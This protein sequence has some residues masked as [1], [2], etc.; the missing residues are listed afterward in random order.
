[1]KTLKKRRKQG[2]TNYLKRLK[3]LKG[4][5]PRIVF[6]KTNKYILAQYVQSKEAQDKVEE[7]I[8]SKILLKYGW[9][10]ESKGSLKSI[11]AAYLTGFLA[12]K[13]ILKGKKETPILDLGMIRTL[14]KSKVYGFA[15]GLVD[16]GV[17]LKIKEEIFPEENRI[18]GKHMKKDFSDAFKKIKSRIQENE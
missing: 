17:K 14:H 10:K 13:K 8:S 5:S 4:R 12:G 18:E 3:L 9:P 6:R 16:A 11:P 15:K 2:K 1:M 7:G